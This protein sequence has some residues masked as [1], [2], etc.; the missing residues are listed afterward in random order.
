MDQGEII[1]AKSIYVLGSPREALEG[2]SR[3]SWLP[4]YVPSALTSVRPERKCSE[5]IIF[6][7]KWYMPIIPA[8]GGP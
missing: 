1:R 7:T 6:G 5:I 4:M 3:V 2:R 8:L